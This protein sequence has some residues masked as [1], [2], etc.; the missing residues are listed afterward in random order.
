MK[1]Q[2]HATP[3]VQEPRSATP[4]KFNAAWFLG[5]WELKDL[6]GGNFTLVMKKLPE[7]WVI[8]H[9]HASK[10]ESADN[11]DSGVISSSEKPMSE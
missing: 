10:E 9:D 7:G 4:L 11:S 8:I 5:R 2:L 6:V 1:G 3:C